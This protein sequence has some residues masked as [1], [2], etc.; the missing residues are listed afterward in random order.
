MI[1]IFVIN[2]IES[3]DRNEI[4]MEKVDFS[5][6]AIT[7]EKELRELLGVPHEYVIKKEISFLDEHCIRFISLS[8]LFFLA[9]ADVRGHCDVSPRGDRP[10]GI[11]ILNPS[12]LVIP[13]R[14]GNKRADS[15]TNILSNPHVGL[16][17]V[18]PGINEVLRINGKATI[19]KSKEIVSEMRLNGKPPLL[20]IGIDVG[21][22]FIHC[23]RALQKSQIW[24][25]DTWEKN[26]TLPSGLDMFHAHLK[27][28]GVEV[29]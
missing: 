1:I 13:D 24:N 17:F 26:E 6:E 8:P 11:K 19:I 10:N 16:V 4:R 21:A 7:T 28:N 14:P 23:A 12:Q 27:I 9:T 5:S 18:I 3:F 29:K 2:F 22:C 25:A 20:G 15:L